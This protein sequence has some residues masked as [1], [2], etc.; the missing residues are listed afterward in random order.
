MAA[1]GQRSKFD[2]KNHISAR[3]LDP[4]HPAQTKFCM[5]IQLNPRNKPVE[6]FSCKMVAGCQKLNFNKFSAPK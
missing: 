4:V 3:H 6:E 1:F 5:D 2:P